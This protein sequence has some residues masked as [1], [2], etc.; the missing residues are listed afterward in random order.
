[1]YWL[2]GIVEKSTAT[3]DHPFCYIGITSKSDVNERLAGHASK[4]NAIRRKINSGRPL[5][6]TEKH[7]MA[8]AIARNGLDN[9]EIVALERHPTKE[10]VGEAEMFA[11]RRY[12]TNQRDMARTGLP[13]YNLSQG[14]DG[15]G[16]EAVLSEKAFQK[17]LKKYEIALRYGKEVPDWVRKKW[18]L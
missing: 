5:L 17:A 18:R 8:G 10:A 6:W 16:G 14:A 4:A 1:M 3:E 12:A 13:G 11:I 15:V 9:Y 7:G 2:Y